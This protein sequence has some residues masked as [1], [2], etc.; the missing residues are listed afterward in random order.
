MWLSGCSGVSESSA[1]TL[2]E[3][4]ALLRAVGIAEREGVKFSWAKEPPHDA[5]F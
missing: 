4:A 2:L 1:A 5:P 3:A